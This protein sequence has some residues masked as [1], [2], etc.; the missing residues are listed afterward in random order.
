[1]EESLYTN[2]YGYII[3]HQSDIPWVKIFSKIPYKELSDCDTKTKEFMFTCMD[4]CERT[5][6]DFYKPEK[7]NIAIFGNYLP[8]LHIHVMARFQ[9]DSHFPEPMWGEKQRESKLVL[10]PF[11]EYVKL[12]KSNLS[13][14]G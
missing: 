4:I 9:D 2:D 12:L 13:T 6:L 8:H 1:M 11:E 10:P 14:R 7:I 5:M 3:K